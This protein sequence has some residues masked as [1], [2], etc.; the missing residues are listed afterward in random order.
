MV[1]PAHMP[2]IKILR[3]KNETNLCWYHTP[4]NP[5]HYFSKRI[6]PTIY[7]VD[8]RS[9][10]TQLLRVLAGDGGSIQCVCV[11][12]S[13]AGT[14]WS[15][16][17]GGSSYD[18]GP[19]AARL[20]SSILLGREAVASLLAWPV[21]TPSWLSARG[22]WYVFGVPPPPAIRALHS[23]ANLGCTDKLFRL[24]LHLTVMSFFPLKNNSVLSL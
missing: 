19:W 2:R 5:K 16:L 17:L 10:T 21:T 12:R 8:V 23:R 7:V 3:L 9:R 15:G 22:P 13:W 4:V 6:I 24:L 20:P 11:S 14:R 18:P 1:A